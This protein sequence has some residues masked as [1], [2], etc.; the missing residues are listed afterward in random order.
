MLARRALEYMEQLPK[1][2]VTLAGLSAVG[3]LGVMDYF[4]GGQFAVSTVCLFPVMVVAFHAGKGA[5]V[6]VSA[7]G[8]GAL[9]LADLLADKSYPYAV[10]IYGNAL[11]CFGCYLVIT[12][13]MV[14]LHDLLR[15]VRDLARTD[16][17]TGVL[18]SR[19][20]CRLAEIE[21]KRGARYGRPFTLAY[22]DLDNFKAVNDG[23]GHSTG[24]NVLQQVADTFRSN[25]RATDLVG[26]LGGDEFAVLLPE[27][28]FEAGGSF[29]SKARQRLLR[30]M[31]DHHWPVTFSIGAVTFTT[32]PVSVDKMIE[33]V[34]ALMY[35]VKR[36]GK[37][38]I[39]HE[40][41]SQA[42]AFQPCHMKQVGGSG[43]TNDGHR[44]GCSGRQW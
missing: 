40:I 37:D 33:M 34:D 13:M 11:V 5:G 1:S 42:A 23:F 36:S 30:A 10:A 2:L 6:L 31:S 21:I 7:G 26:R 19:E 22:I 16:S 24:N 17:L 43:T 14:T 20:F 9:W 35:S 39:R 3:L 18:N 32:P 41:G 8:A 15:T 29:L 28:G 44:S 25:L 4:T 27:T 38:T 12:A